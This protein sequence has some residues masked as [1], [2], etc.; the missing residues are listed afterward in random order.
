MSD[1]EMR[2]LDKWT[3]INV[4]DWQERQ[5]YHGSAKLEGQT[6]WV[7]KGRSVTPVA[8]SKHHEFKKCTTDRAAAMEVLNKIRESGVVVVIHGDKEVACSQI[9]GKRNGVIA[10]TLPLAIALFAKAIFS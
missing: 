2:E 6:F 4:L 5:A 7:C 3:C 8:F 10:E 1:D 9:G